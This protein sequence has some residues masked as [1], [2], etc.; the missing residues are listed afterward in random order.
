MWRRIVE[1]AG[2]R[3]EVALALVPEAAERARH[4]FNVALAFAGLFLG[5]AA[6]GWA[7]PALCLS[8]AAAVADSLRR[9]WRWRSIL[10]RLEE[11][12]AGDPVMGLREVL[13]DDAVAL[14][15]MALMLYVLGLLVSLGLVP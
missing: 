5:A 8:F 2:S 10:K 4:W 1:K 15:L 14:T 7:R 6:L 13:D 11:I 12:V 9:A 3:P